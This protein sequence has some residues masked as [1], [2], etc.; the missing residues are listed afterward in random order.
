MI[1][2]TTEFV[3]AETGEVLGSI[4]T[5]L[6]VFDGNSGEAKLATAI[7]THLVG[8]GCAPENC[9]KPI[10]VIATLDY[11]DGKATQVRATFKNLLNW[12]EEN[13]GRGKR[14]RRRK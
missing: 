3:N 1:K 14:R 8:Y 9:N 2:R 7:A 10:I 12:T 6:D 5:F 13:E 11:G 4:D